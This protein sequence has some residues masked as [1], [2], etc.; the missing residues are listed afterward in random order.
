M[1]AYVCVRMSERV[2]ESES[3]RQR[4]GEGEG[5]GDD[6]FKTFTSHHHLGTLLPIFI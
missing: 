5:D 4:E 3:K 1:C 6:H 2:R